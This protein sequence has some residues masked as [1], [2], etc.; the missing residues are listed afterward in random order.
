MKITNIRV[1]N[2]Y[3]IKLINATLAG[4]NTTE[5]IVAE[6]GTRS[7]VLPTPANPV[8]TFQEKFNVVMK[9]LISRYEPGW[10]AADPVVGKAAMM[11]LLGVSSGINPLTLG[12]TVENAFNVLSSTDAGWF[13][14]LT[15]PKDF[16][17][18]VKAAYRTFER[19]R[20]PA[21][22]KHRFVDYS[23][24]GIGEYSYSRS[25][26]NMFFNMRSD[27]LWYLSLIHI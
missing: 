25:G 22:A 17:T 14:P 20:K 18:A 26:G 6:Q 23:V 11:A 24:N 7:P 19:A 27:S 4:V 12:G 15:H 21:K 8:R 16:A 1:L 2:N 13:D 10:S 5:N 3:K 9:Y